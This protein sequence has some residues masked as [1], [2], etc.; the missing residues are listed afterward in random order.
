MLTR[1]LF[2]K[3]TKLILTVALIVAVLA[4]LFPGGAVRAAGTTIS[5]GGANWSV[6]DDFG[7][8]NGLPQGGNCSFVGAGNG[9]TVQDAKIS[10]QNDAFDLGVM[11]WVNN[12]L[13]GGNLSQA[14]NTV[15]FSP[16]AIAGLSVQMTYDGLPNRT[17]RSFLTLTNPTGTCQ[18]MKECYRRVVAASFGLCAWGALGRSHS[19]SNAW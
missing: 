11:T 6:R 3:R 8:S 14:G 15:T 4:S 1:N 18:L 16:V 13:V 10:G 17:L 2:S 5:T 9:A 19:R 7:T 12:T